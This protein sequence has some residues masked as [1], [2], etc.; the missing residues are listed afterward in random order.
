MKNLKVQKCTSIIQF[1]ELVIFDCFMGSSRTNSSSRITITPVHGGVTVYLKKCMVQLFIFL[2]FRYEPNHSAQSVD[3]HWFKVYI[4]KQEYSMY[5]NTDFVVS[6][7][8]VVE[9]IFRRTGPCYEQTIRQNYQLYFWKIVNFLLTNTLYCT[10]SRVALINR[11]NL[12]CKE[13]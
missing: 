2:W 7:C 9:R 13:Y 10:F 6:Y 8:T 3:S 5:R 11:K 4:N 1:L 12:N